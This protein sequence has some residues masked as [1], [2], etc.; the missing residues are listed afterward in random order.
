MDIHVGQPGEF[1]VPWVHAPDM[2]SER[3]LPPMWIVR[4]IEVVVS[5]RVR[6]ERGVVG[7][8]SQRQG[9]AAA[10]TPNQLCGDQFTFFLGVSISAQE[11]I[12]RAD[13]GLILAEA[14]VGAVATK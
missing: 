7:V 4:V 12:E 8:R 1:R 3:H 10:P 13:A 6:T 9:G 5:L 14:H 11:T 2:R